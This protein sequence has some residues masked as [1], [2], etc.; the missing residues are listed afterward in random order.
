MLN[1]LELQEKLTAVALPSGFEAPQG[2]ILADLARPL[3][4]QVWTDAIGNVFCRK[5]GKGKGLMFAAHMDVIGL[6]VT[7]VDDKGFL[8]F[9]PIG[10]HS[11]AGLIGITVRLES[12]VRGTI[13]NDA[14]ADV[15][16]NNYHAVD[17]HDLF[18]DIGAESREEAEELAPI[19]SVAVFDYKPVMVSGSTMMTP[20]ADD[21]CSCAA[22][23]IAM[24]EL[25]GVETENDLT[26]VFT[27]QEEVGLRGAQPAA[28]DVRP[29]M[30][31]A[32]DVTRTGDTPGEIDGQRMVV[33]L[34]KGPA[35]KHKDAS[36]QCNPQVIAHLEKAAKAA[37]IAVQSEV[38]LA[39]GTDT[40]AIQRSREGVLS[41]C[42]SLP[43][44]NI[45]TPGE[46]VDLK[47]VEQAGK[48]LAAAAKIA[49]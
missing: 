19:G 28:W 37:R 7:F 26:F 12:G 23:L 43:C 10:G 21:L 36:V 39:G 42:V 45:H 6:M 33:A 13:R 38:L 40:L 29:Y 35:I 44:R 2:K 16:K 11:P 30:G 17:V 46:M 15:Y 24:E 27:V 1:I 32:V 5:K 9:E 41:G 49:L 47:D 25:Q 22:L 48:L 20:Y 4:D 8:R 18:I 31:I 3:V 14:T 34:G